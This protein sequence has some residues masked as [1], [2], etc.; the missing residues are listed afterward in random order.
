MKEHTKI[1]G[2][3]DIKLLGPDGEVKEHMKTT[4]LITDSGFDGLIQ[5]CFSTQTGSPAFNYIAI[6]SD[7]TAASTSDTSLGYLLAVK[8]GTYS[9][10]DGEHNFELSATFGAGVGTGSI[11]EYAIQ[12]GSP[13]GTIFNRA[14]FG[15]IV[16]G[17]Q[18]SLQI[19]FAGSLS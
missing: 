5:R 18:D 13:S 12:N 7:G 9:H 2:T 16:K 6:G 15:T 1:K 3:W 10:T 8:Q 14:T 11:R 19:V 4:N 17:S